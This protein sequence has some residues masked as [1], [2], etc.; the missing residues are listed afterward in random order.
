MYLFVSSLSLV[1]KT[2]MSG[3]KRTVEEMDPDYEE[4][5]I[6]PTN[7]H[8]KASEQSGKISLKKR[9]VCD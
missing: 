8:H 4:I 6:A 9:T 7:K 3:I 1:K 5:S 2:A